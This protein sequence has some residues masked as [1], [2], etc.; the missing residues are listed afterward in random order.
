MEM[1]VV[2]KTKNEVTGTLGSSSPKMSKKQ[3]FTS[4]NISEP[5]WSSPS[6]RGPM[7]AQKH[8]WLQLL[9]FLINPWTERILLWWG[10]LFYFCWYPRW[11]SRCTHYPC[12]VCVRKFGLCDCSEDTSKLNLLVNGEMQ[13]CNDF[14]GHKWKLFLAQSL[15]SIKRKTRCCSNMATQVEHVWWIANTPKILCPNKFIHEI[16]VIYKVSGQTRAWWTS[17]NLA[18]HYAD[19]WMN[20][21]GHKLLGV[22]L[23]HHKPSGQLH[24]HGTTILS[25]RI[26]DHKKDHTKLVKGR[27]NQRMNTRSVYVPIDVV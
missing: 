15:Y 20:L 23:I 10:L 24:V 27:N 18:Y 12:E 26:C 6:G 4:S 19:L 5:T 16:R 13:A 1:V 25:N 7:S 22:L 2:S 14:F 17:Q 8:C 9:Y 21:Y 11:L 3:A